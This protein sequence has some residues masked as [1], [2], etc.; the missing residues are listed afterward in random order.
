M[1]F[2]IECKY[3]QVLLMAGD[4]NV[5]LIMNRLIY[6][7]FS[8]GG[9]QSVFVTFSN[10]CNLFN[11]NKRNLNLFH[12]ALTQRGGRCVESVSY[13]ERTVNRVVLVVVCIRV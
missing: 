11:I 7:P 4:H 10:S 5:S 8:H 13:T 6:W 3:C 9:Q 2:F 12:A 1:F